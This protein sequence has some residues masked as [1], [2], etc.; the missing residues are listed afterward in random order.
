M[1]TIAVVNQKGGC[2]KTITSINL[3]AFLAREQ[4]RVLLV[5]MD[6]QGHST[7]GLQRET[8]SPERTMYDVLSGD[9][10]KGEAR[11][12][13]VILPVLDN[14]DVAP[15]DILL[16]A[17][18]QRLGAI[19]GR[20]N[21]LADSLKEVDG[22]YDYVLIDCPPGVGLL[23]FNAL[24]ACSEAI[25]PMDPSFFSL[26]GIGKLLETLDVLG[27][28][29]G[30]EISIRA[31]ITLY[32]G[33]SRFVKEV[34]EDIRKHLGDRCFKTVIRFSVKLAEAASHGLPITHYARRCV[35]FAD[36]GALALEVIQ[37]EDSAA[38]SAAER[39]VPQAGP[40]TPPS[41]TEVV[42]ERVE[43]VPALDDVPEL[44]APRV[45]DKGIVFTLESPD[46]EQVQ[47]VGDFNDWNPQGSDM[48]RVGRI[49]RKLLPLPP[50][51]YQYRYLVDGRWQSDPLN[52]E[53]EHS[54]FGSDNSVFVLAE[55]KFLR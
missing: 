48:K 4:R 10:G 31:L 35:G 11:L 55:K 20:E 24:K 53:A 28:K 49:W 50:G 43:H 39:R 26:H 46:A 22:E 42:Q 54:P 40:V 17:V 30:H 13:D 29:T 5:D 23:T 47:L 44:S 18:P 19:F 45:T 41:A 27:K 36:Y 33:R 15:S 21:R 25:I 38:R 7:L 16:S 1:R 2:G 34:V 37:A 51:R 14:L 12:R 9:T 3:S 6:P 52:C 8:T 32:T